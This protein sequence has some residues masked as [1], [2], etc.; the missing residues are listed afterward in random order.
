VSHEELGEVV[1]LAVKTRVP[2]KYLGELLNSVR[3]NSNLDEKKLP[4]VIVSMDELP[5][6]LAGKTKRIGLQKRLGLPSRSLYRMEPVAYTYSRGKLTAIDFGDDENLAEAMDSLGLAKAKQGV[7]I[8]SEIRNTILAVYGLSAFFVVCYNGQLFV[9]LPPGTSAWG[10]TAIRML[11]GFVPGGVCWPMQ[12]FMACASFL[13]CH[14]PFQITRLVILLL[15]YFLFQWPFTSLVYWFSYVVSGEP[16]SLNVYY[17]MTDKRW[18]VAVMIFCY[19]SFAFC[20]HLP[21]HRFQC[22][23]LVLLTTALAIWPVNEYVLLNLL[24]EWAGYWFTLRFVGGLF[25]WTALV[26]VYFIVGYYGHETLA[27]VR[28]HPIVADPAFQRRLRTICPVLFIVCLIVL[29][30]SPAAT[31][32]L[33]T[34]ASQRSW[35]WDPWTILLDQG[36][37]LVMIA[38]L[39]Q[40]VRCMGPWLVPIGSCALGIYLGGDIAFFCP[41]TRNNLQEASFGIILNKVAVVPTLQTMITNLNGIWPL[42]CG[43]VFLYTWFQIFVFGMPLHWVYLKLLT[44]L[45]SQAK[46]WWLGSR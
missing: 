9:Q 35:L 22:A 10:T 44:F 16:P 1:G 29:F 40:T 19:A 8:P 32:A 15:F 26:M 12:C 33:A 4:E 34:G 5:K 20:R 41:F 24:P 18:F 6:G 14:E 17:V 46:S 39:S 2:A 30:S 13:L 27:R 28:T 23:F 45:D 36:A 21:Y 38:L 7:T 3:R 37:A 43:I 31:V 25:C 11:V 42:Q